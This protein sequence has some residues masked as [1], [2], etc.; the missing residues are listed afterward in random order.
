MLPKLRIA[1]SSSLIPI[2]FCI[3]FIYLFINKKLYRLKVLKN[4][5]L[6]VIAKLPYF[7]ILCRSKVKFKEILLTCFFNQTFFFS[8]L[9]WE[10]FQY[11]VL[12]EK[13][14]FFFFPFSKLIYKSKTKF[15]K[16]LPNVFFSVPYFSPY[17]AIMLS[18]CSMLSHRHNEKS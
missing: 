12:Y 9:R 16:F 6:F 14:V 15:F 4:F 8:I 5:P 1:F 18:V 7:P 2:F 17:H 11:L 3:I 10:R 13:F